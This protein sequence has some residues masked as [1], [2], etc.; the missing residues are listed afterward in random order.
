MLYF[1][2]QNITS[3]VSQQLNLLEKKRGDKKIKPCHTIKKLLYQKKIKLFLKC[4]KSFFHN[5]D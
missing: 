2:D 5:R 1:N 3:F 4:Q